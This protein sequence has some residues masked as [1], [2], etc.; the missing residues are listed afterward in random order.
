MNEYI[1]YLALLLGAVGLVLG[2]LAF[3]KASSHEKSKGH[4][5]IVAT[6]GEGNRTTA[7]TTFS[8]NTY[9][10]KVTITFEGKVQFDDNSDQHILATVSGNQ[11]IMNIEGIVPT[12]GKLGFSIKV[13][14]TFPEYQIDNKYT[15]VN[16]YAYT[17]ASSTACG[18]DYIIVGS[19]TFV[20]GQKV[21][22]YYPKITKD[23]LHCPF[24]HFGNCSTSASTVYGT[25]NFSIS[26]ARA[27]D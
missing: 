24:T 20:K 27:V 4:Y 12:E 13:P 9:S 5:H 23:G 7:A 16:V 25:D 26:F 14:W 15:P 6:D 10:G 11:V 1:V 21:G 18:G 17:L 22:Y 3:D 19:K 2:S 8:R